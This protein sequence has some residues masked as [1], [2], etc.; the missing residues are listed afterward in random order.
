MIQSQALL[1]VGGYDDPL[2]PKL[3]AAINQAQEIE[4]A[5]SFVRMSGYA[6]LSGALIDALERGAK[7]SFLTSDYLGVTEPAALRSLMLLKE[8]GAD[9]RAHQY[10]D[11]QS[12]HMKS[13]I[14]LR[15]R[16]GENIEGCAYIGSSN[17]SKAALTTGHEWNLRLECNGSSHDPYVQQFQHVRHQF[18]QIFQHSQSYTLS[19]EWIAEYIT[20]YQQKKL[21]AVEALTAEDVE[22]LEISPSSVQQ[23]ALAALYSSRKEGY[24]RGLVVLA[25]GLG[26]TWLSAFDSIQS[27]AETVLFVAHREEILLQAEET[28]VRLR[29]ED[30]TGFYNGSEQTTD[31]DLLFASI[32][33]LGKTNHLEKF[34]PDHFDYIVVDEFHHASA[35]T[36]QRLLS[37][38]KPKFLL[39][40]TAT[41]ERTD[42]ADILSLCDNNLVFERNLSFGINAKLLSPFHYYG[43][44]D[45]HVDY[46]EI[47]WRSGRFDTE[48]LATAFASR[49]RAKHILGHWEQRK[50]SRTLAFCISK[51]HAEFMAH[52]FRKAGYKSAAV[53]SGSQTPRNQALSELSS[54][55][56]DI[57][58]SIDLFNE[59]TDLPA[60]DTLLMLRPTESKIV[61]LQQLG[62][63][64]RLYDRKDHLVV[65]DFIGNHQSFLLKPLALHNC[66]TPAQL[67][68]TIKEPMLTL[69]DSCHV[70]YEPIVIDL[71]GRMI[72]KQKANIDDEYQ[73]LKSILGYRP[74]A[75]EFYHYLNQAGIPFNKVRQRYGSWFE[76]LSEQQELKTDEDT[77]VAAFKTFLL[78]AVEKAPMTKCFKMILLEAFI[79]LDG[80]VTPPTEQELAERSWYILSRRP[81]LLAKDLPERL[82][83]V[84]ADSKEWLKYWRSN[85]IKAFISGE[86]P[87]FSVESGSFSLTQTIEP[88][89]AIYLTQMTRELVQMRLEQYKKR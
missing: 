81:D 42:Q 89:Q 14:F 30:K 85:P 20:R 77:A 72:R 33:T 2:L 38:F 58:F 28:F 88:D 19:H 74:T 31:A 44:Q 5:V 70:N 18:E 61:F 50:Q 75:T 45:Q 56:L 25:T 79:E 32:Q 65:I 22:S 34:S 9:I 83:G 10:A 11:G 54:G 64:L 62:R 53:Y 86:K 6:L 80:F 68:Q 40:L 3:I 84:T 15:S 71:L 16:K 27:K 52:F 26:K 43:I 67:A 4:V 1:T 57:I 17:I 12:F 63:G 49:R 29:P 78:D 66:S 73:S 35:Q 23:D 82:E 60:I 37:Y 69:P 87:W 51:S 24:Q 47:P 48:T 39:G 13:Y 8:R 46:E 21:I 76:M 55:T 36:Y 7:I 59:G 41:P